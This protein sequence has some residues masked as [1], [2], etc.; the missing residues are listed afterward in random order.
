ME[1]GELREQLRAEFEER[2]PNS[3]VAAVAS[4]WLEL[5]G[6]G[7]SQAIYQNR[8]GI[9]PPLLCAEVPPA[10]SGDCGCVSHTIRQLSTPKAILP[11]SCVILDIICPVMFIQTAPLRYTSC[12]SLVARQTLRQRSR[13]FSSYRVVFASLSLVWRLGF[14]MVVRLPSSKLACHNQHL[15]CRTSRARRLASGRAPPLVAFR[16]FVIR[17]KSYQLCVDRFAFVFFVCVV[18]VVATCLW[19]SPPCFFVH[20]SPC[21]LVVVSVLLSF[22]ISGPRFSCPVCLFL[23]VSSGP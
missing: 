6:Q 3:T 5:K 10:M 12:S 15:T 9:H 17:V 22:G 21:F 2:R 20:L 19:F 7:P 13:M 1:P 18:V 23:S 8:S 16:L 14:G 4:P 11:I